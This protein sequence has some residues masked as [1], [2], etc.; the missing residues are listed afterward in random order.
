LLASWCDA[1]AAAAWRPAH[2]P[3]AKPVRHRQVRIIRDYGMFERHE[4]PQFYP[5]VER[6]GAG[7][8]RPQRAAA[9]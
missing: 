1:D 5:D 6:P 4:A 8:E 9:Q 7:A 2:L 3:A